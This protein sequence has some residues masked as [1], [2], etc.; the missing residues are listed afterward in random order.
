MPYEICACCVMIKYIWNLHEYLRSEWRYS[1]VIDQFGKVWVFCTYTNLTWD[2]RPILGQLNPR[3]RFTM[4][5]QGEKAETVVRA[6][7]K[8]VN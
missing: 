2:F 1:L 8:L 3:S 5:L 6:C 4:G 7:S